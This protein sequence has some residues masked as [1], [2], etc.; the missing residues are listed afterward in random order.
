MTRVSHDK[1]MDK[2]SRN[3][4][5][6]IKLI[7]MDVDGVLTAGEIIL[8]DN[9]EEIKMWNVWD[10][11]G[12]TLGRKGG[13]RYAW[14]TG[15]ESSQV[16]ARAREIKIDA[17]YQRCME[18]YE[19]FSKVMQRFGLSTDECAFIGDD[20]VDLPVLRRVGFSVCPRDARPELKDAVDHVAKAEGGRG[21]LRE[22]VEMVLKAQGK[23]E[24]VL[25][26]YDK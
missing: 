5:K 23:W 20:I 18:K 11:M 14:I 26:Q 3:R 13:L 15:R 16:A 7:G 8:F 9:G 4:L 1:C 25:K 22:V 6:K 21:V 2:N 12:F 17:L 19:A 10:R 24:L